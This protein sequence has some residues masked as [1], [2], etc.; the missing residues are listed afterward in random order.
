[1]AQDEFMHKPG[2]IFHGLLFEIPEDIQ[3]PEYTC[4]R[5]LVDVSCSVSG[6]P[7]H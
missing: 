4:S 7:A 6:D 1:M 5:R 2:L 3:S